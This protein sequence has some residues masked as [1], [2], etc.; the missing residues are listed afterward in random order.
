MQGLTRA[1]EA[2]DVLEHG[3]FDEES[4]AL[5]TFGHVVWADMDA[6][7][8]HVQ[9]AWT[10]RTHRAECS[11]EAQH[12]AALCAEFASCEREREA[13]STSHGGELGM[14]MSAESIARSHGRAAAR[15][16][17][18][19]RLTAFGHPI[20]F[21]RAQIRASSLNQDRSW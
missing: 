4:C 9:T 14:A 2:C 5:Q 3:V 12:G 19:T 17:K 20:E 10:A 11:F 6:D 16:P 1:A 21:A 18:D 7:E 15:A 13:G 8:L